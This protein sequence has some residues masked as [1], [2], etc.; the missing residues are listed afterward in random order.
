M[1]MSKVNKDEADK[2]KQ[3]QFAK[4]T[5]RQAAKRKQAND[6]K[7]NLLKVNIDRAEAATLAAEFGITKDHA[8]IVLR[9]QNGN[10]NDAMEHLLKTRPELPC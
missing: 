5:E 2:Q 3:A 1:A 4:L 7:D 9:E 10:F 6:R 8:E